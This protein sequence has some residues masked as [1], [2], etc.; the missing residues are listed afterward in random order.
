MA[1][2]NLSHN[3]KITVLTY[4]ITPIDYQILIIFTV[5]GD[6]RVYGGGWDYTWWSAVLRL[7]SGCCGSGS[8][9]YICCRWGVFRL[10]S[11]SAFYL[12]R[13]LPCSNLRSNRQEQRCRACPSPVGCASRLST[14]GRSSHKDKSCAGQKTE[15]S[16][17][18]NS[19]LPP[20]FLPLMSLLEE[21]NTFIQLRDQLL[22]I[23]HIYEWLLSFPVFFAKIELCIMSN[24]IG[25]LCCAAHNLPYV[26]KSFMLA[27]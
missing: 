14:A 7:L 19:S 11:S 23:F 17:A 12:P 2:L 22:T 18:T 10:Y 8:Y 20:R 25:R 6:F 26:G 27:S 15:S 1:D 16:I 24:S 9:C 4:L 21:S 5:D 3:P 13:S